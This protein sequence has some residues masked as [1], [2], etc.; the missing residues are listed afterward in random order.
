[1]FAITSYALVLACRPCAYLLQ[2]IECCLPCL[3]VGSS[4]VPT[5]LTQLIEL[6]PPVGDG[7]LALRSQQ[8]PQTG[9]TF[10]MLAMFGLTAKL[11]S[12]SR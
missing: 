5:A 8:R 3:G 10:L 9:M 11:S 6:L 4:A 1:M 7:Y 2:E 12:G